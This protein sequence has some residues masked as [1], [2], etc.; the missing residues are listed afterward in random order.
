[1]RR[2]DILDTPS[3]ERFDRVARLVKRWFEVPIALISFLD[4]HREW[5]KSQIGLGEDELPR[6]V[7]FCEHVVQK[8]STMVVED[9]TQDPRFVDNP[10]VAESP[11]VRFYAGAPL[12]TP[13]GH[14][15][16]AVC[17]LDT[18][19]RTSAPEDLDVLRDSADIVADELEFRATCQK[20]EERTRQA[21]SLS[22]ALT[23]AE[24]SERR[25]L[26]QLLHD[27]LQQ[28]LHSARMRVEGLRENLSFSDEES[29]CAVQIE[30][31]LH[32]ATEIARTLSTQFAPPFGDS[33]LRDAIDWLA[34]KMEE[35]HDLS[36]SVQARGPVNIS[37]EVLRTLLFRL[38][39][40]LLF[41]IV[42]HAGT[43][44]ARV[45]LVEGAD[46]LR[47]VVED[48]GKGFDPAEE[49]Q[50]GFGL[51]NIRERIELMG[52]TVRIHSTPGEG[53]RIVMEVPHA[54]EG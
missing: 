12:A 10:L 50:G 18:E 4:A 51:A 1:M 41:N 38:V 21:E 31:Q 32:E 19:P 29:A 33:S 24:E 47:V 44:E 9:T 7:A 43:D 26:S 48:E 3:E 42:K 52:G 8:Q 35:I 37:E 28:V 54:G 5:F 23:K 2:Y 15:L 40:E 22:E 13:D 53:T 46:A 34:M 39:R 36:V 11:G 20:L 17:V 16:G 14:C 30:E 49:V 6:E 45:L 27:D 25:R